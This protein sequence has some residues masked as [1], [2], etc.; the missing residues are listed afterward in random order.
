MDVHDKKTR[1]FNMSKIRGIDTKPEVMVRKYLFSKG[2]RFRIND[3][4]YPGHPDIVLPKYKTCVFINGC[5]WHAHEGCKYF[6]WPKSN[7]EF[8]KKKINGNAERDKRTH[9]DLISLGWIVIVVWECELK[10]N[11]FEVKM[12][13]LI[14][15]ITTNPEYVVRTYTA[16]S[17]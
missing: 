4:R 12:T 17:L 11:N 6:V 13:S 7:S 16:Q 14:E 3:K 10:G 8:W 5:F 1:S 2:F 15:K 9:T